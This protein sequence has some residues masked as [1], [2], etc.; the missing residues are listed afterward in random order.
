MPHVAGWPEWTNGTTMT[1]IPPLFFFDSHGGLWATC[2]G[3]HA[4]AVAF[5]PRGCARPATCKEAGLEP[6][7][8]EEGGGLHEEAPTMAASRVARLVTPRNEDDCHLWPHIG[9]PDDEF[10]VGGW[11]VRPA[12]WG[13]PELWAFDGGVRGWLGLCY[14]DGPAELATLAGFERPGQ[15]K[16][17]AWAL[18]MLDRQIRKVYG[19]TP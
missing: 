16:P 15:R 11:L 17:P 5:G 13:A 18:E 7:C 19:L 6:L 10:E 12:S 2:D 14:F 4:A 8:W 1:T 9:E 3:G